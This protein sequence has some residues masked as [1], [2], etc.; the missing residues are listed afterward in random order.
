MRKEV[1]IICSNHDNDHDLHKLGTVP[2]LVVSLAGKAHRHNSVIT[3]KRS[4]QQI[5][6]SRQVTHYNY[7]NILIDADGLRNSVV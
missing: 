1:L 7:R 3:A 4:F 2:Y 5:Q 6:F